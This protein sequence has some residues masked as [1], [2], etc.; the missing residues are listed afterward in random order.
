MRVFHIGADHFVDLDD[1][2]AQL[3]TSGFLWVGSA[4]REF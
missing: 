3:P 1:L 4:R 2:P